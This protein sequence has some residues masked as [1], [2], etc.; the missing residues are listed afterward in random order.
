M[1]NN[2]KLKYR[3][4]DED[5]TRLAVWYLIGAFVFLAFACM[6]HAI[7]L[8]WAVIVYVAG[9]VLVAIWSDIQKIRMMMEMDRFENE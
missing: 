8:T 7:S 4:N 6:A 3:K 1:T 9:F 2:D 5:W